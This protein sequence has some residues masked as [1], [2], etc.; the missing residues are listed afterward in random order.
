M[1]DRGLAMYDKPTY[2]Q[3]TARIAELE[4]GAAG[5]HETV[6]ALRQEQAFTSAV[7]KTSGALVVVLD[8]DGRIVR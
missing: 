3:L 2:E 7:M 4:Q 6:A 8:R 5:N 1:G